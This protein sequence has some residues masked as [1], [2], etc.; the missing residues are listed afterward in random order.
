MLVLYNFLVGA[1]EPLQPQFQA[2]SNAHMKL[3]L[4]LHNTTYHNWSL[5]S[6][7][8]LFAQDGANIHVLQLCPTNQ[9]FPP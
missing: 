8:N 1:A 3:Y 4:S 2:V 6:S 9:V 7:S 5:V